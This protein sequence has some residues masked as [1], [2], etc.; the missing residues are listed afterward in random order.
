MYTC[1]LAVLFLHLDYFKDSST[2]KSASSIFFSFW[3][4]FSSFFFCQVF[5]GETA[6]AFYT[7]KNPTDKPII[8]ISTYNV[9]PFEAGQYFNKIQVDH[10]LKAFFLKGIL[11]Y[12]LSSLTFFLTKPRLQIF[13]SCNYSINTFPLS[14]DERTNWYRRWFEILIQ[15]G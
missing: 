7:A 6:L 12:Y 2:A 5:P 13:L 4:I 14:V 15:W 11:L 10:W 3:L 8:G 1:L 9:V